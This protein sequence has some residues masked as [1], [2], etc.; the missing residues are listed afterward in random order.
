[1]EA[2][3]LGEGHDAFLSVDFQ[4]ASHAT[5]TTRERWSEELYSGSPF[6][7]EP[8]PVLRSWNKAFGGDL[9]Q[10]ESEISDEL[11]AH[12]RYP[13]DLFKVQRNILAQYHVTRPKTFYEGSDQWEV[14]QDPTNRTQTQPPYRL[15]VRT[16]SG[17]GD[18]PVFSHTSVYVPKNRQN[19]AAFISVDADAAAGEYGKIRILRLPG[20]TQIPGPSQIA[21]QFTEA[22]DDL[23]LSALMARDD[24]EAATM[25]SEM[26]A[27]LQ[28]PRA[29]SSLERLALAWANRDLKDLEAYGEW[30]DCLNTPTEREMYARLLDGRNP[31]LAESIERLHAEDSVFAAVGA[32]HMVGPQGL[33]SLLNARGFT[34][35]RMF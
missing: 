3:G 14:P 35:T 12:L 19:L 34:V 20:S 16:P 7:G 24:E 33:P 10:P 22:T 21:N 28:R 13:E 25:V 5:V 32:L 17:G 23:Q 2:R 11:R 15:S 29:A 26:L 18:E 4:D 9:I 31:G 27:E 8:D 6:A 30:C 1:M